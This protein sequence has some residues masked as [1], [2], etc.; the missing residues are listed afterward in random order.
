MVPAHLLAVTA[1]A[2]CVVVGNESG[3]TITAV[4]CACLQTSFSTDRGNPFFFTSLLYSSIASIF[5]LKLKGN[6]GA[7]F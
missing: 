7:D 1:N 3:C 5:D 2:K 4:Q 6:L